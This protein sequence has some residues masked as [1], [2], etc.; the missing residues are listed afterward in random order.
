MKKLVLSVV[1]ALA[2]TA[3]VPAFAADMPVKAKRV[4][5]ATPSPWDIA[6][7]TALTSDYVLRGVSQSNHHVATQGYFGE[8]YT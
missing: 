3:A 6:F 4:A 2:V 1:A 8:L 5:V 7:G